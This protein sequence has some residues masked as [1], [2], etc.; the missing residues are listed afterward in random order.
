MAQSRLAKKSAKKHETAKKKMQE[1]M[2]KIM[3]ETAKK[4]PYDSIM[5]FIDKHIQLNMKTGA[6]K[7]CQKPYYKGKYLND[8]YHTYSDAKKQAYMN[9]YDTLVFL[10]EKY[11]IESYGITS[12]SIW[13]FTFAAVFGTCDTKYVIWFSS[14]R[15]NISY[16]GN[17]YNSC[18]MNIKIYLLEEK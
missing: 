2:Q 6:I 13:S 15:N 16:Y 10:S 12:S 3:E 7:S 18:G 9:C 4:F 17:K 8:V 14:D 11:F 1:R 5:E